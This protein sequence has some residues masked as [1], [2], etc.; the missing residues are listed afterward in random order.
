ML[1]IAPVVFSHHRRK[2]GT[3]N[4]KIRVT[5]KGV[6]KYI[7]TNLWCSKDDLTRS[8]KIKTPAIVDA[9]ARL[10]KELR[11]SV[12][13]LSPALMENLTADDIVRRMKT[14]R[15]AE[16]FQLDFFTYGSDFAA[17]KS[18]STAHAYTMA[19]GALERFVGRRSLDVN[20]ITKALLLDFIKAVD[21]APKMHYNVQAKTWDES[22]LAKQPHGQSYRH[23]AKLAAIYNAARDE[24]NDEDAGLLLIPRNPFKGVKVEAPKTVKAQNALPVEMIQRIID[25]ERAEGDKS[26]KTAL[27]TFLL[28]FGTMGANLADLYEARPFKGGTWVY[29]RMKTRER[30]EDRAEIHIDIQPEVCRYVAHLQGDKRWWL[31]GL[32]DLNPKADQITARINRAL[33]RWCAR[34][35]VEPF[36]FYA[37][38]HSWATIARSK[39]KIDKATVDESLDH[40][41]DYQL[42]DIYLEKDWSIINKANTEVLALLDFHESGS[43]SAGSAE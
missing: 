13:D 32:H 20:D 38:R 1:T 2:D 19:L 4:V 23:I 12:S 14:H 21:E 8:L 33:R 29:Y 15:K 10:V 28:S 34:E 35:G 40:V 42:A 6:N 5:W 22:G 17:K 30:R 39:A 37:A 9:A 26:I 3:Y 11:D 31:G 27:A 24:F 25:A 7:A 18:K 43:S 36:T 41:G 16:S